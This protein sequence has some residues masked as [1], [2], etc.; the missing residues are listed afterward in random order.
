MTVNKL[1]NKF[2]SEDIT[3][4]FAELKNIYNYDSIEQGRKDYIVELVQK[5]GYLPYPHIKALEELTPAETLLGLEEKFKYNNVFADNKFSFEPKLISPAVSNGFT[6]SSWINNEQHSIKLI[7]LAAL[8]NGN[9]SKA[10]AKFIDLLKQL[11]ILPAGNLENKVLA[12]TVYLIPFHP[13]DFGCAYLPTS[14][15]VSPNLE[16]SL[17][18]DALGMDSKEQVKLFISLCQLGG[19]CVMFDVL[20][21]TGRFSKTVLAK[22]YIARWFDVKELINLLNSD[23]IDIINELK[24]KYSSTDLEI[25]K[26]IIIMSL[27]GNSAEI[28]EEIKPLVEDIELK[29]VKQKKIHSENMLL[30]KN[31][32]II[33]SKT[34]LLINKLAGFDENKNLTEDEITNQGEIIG[35][36]IK[37]GLWPAPGGAWCSS[38]IPIFDKMN[39]GGSYPLFKHFDNEGKDV[40]EMANLDCQTPYYFVYLENGEYNE[41]VVD[42]YVEFLKN[43]QQEFNFDAFRV[44]HIDHIVDAVSENKE[45]QPISY[46]AP[47]KVLGKANSELKKANPTFA[48][49]AEYMLWDNFYKEYHQDMN[50]DVLWGSD[51][52]SQFAKTVKQIIADNKALELYNEENPIAT[53]KLSILKTYN[54]QDGEFRAIDQYPGQLGAKGALFKWLKFKLIPGGKLAQRP[55]LYIDG[56][57]SFTKVGTEKVIGSEESMERANDSEFYREFNS[58]NSFALKNP[59][60]CF[61]QAELFEVAEEEKTFV[62][63]IIKSNNES[64]NEILF[65]V[66]NECPPTE[67]L[68]IYNENSEPVISIKEGVT[69]SNITAKIPENFKI[70]SEFI[71]ENGQSEFTENSS[72][73]ALCNEKLSFETLVPSEYHIYKLVK[74]N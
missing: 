5:H 28:S 7:N 9:E 22:S 16:D 12:T 1:L 42:F 26:N 62:S 72:I 64:D 10:P 15:G 13:R 66:A 51:I 39:Q 29:L 73:Q 57:E 67:V 31:Q 47:R 50:F 3:Q 25:V 74:I 41:K 59:L 32:E 49:L 40:T 55:V 60:T 38:G 65:I 43:L 35:E 33:H 58:I 46:R 2:L 63:W 34:Q 21:Q 52:I 71:L 37:N 56:D 4:I 18:K 27:N 30:M 70:V 11:L 69:L 36:L 45:E 53:N 17:I 14:S 23:L 20:P 61:G 8:G 48:T 68:K 54:N 6:D 24:N 19:H 44:D